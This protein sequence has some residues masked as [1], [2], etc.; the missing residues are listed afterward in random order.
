[1]DL[2]PEKPVERKGEEKSES[3]KIVDLINSIYWDDITPAADKKA[4]TAIAY[5]IK[6]ARSSAFEEAAKIAEEH[7]FCIN[8]NHAELK[9]CPVG[10]ATANL[11]RNHDKSNPENFG[12]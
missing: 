12:A 5:F 10:K 7:C 4:A 8:E 6:K 9:N 1:M 11:I 3:D 2:N